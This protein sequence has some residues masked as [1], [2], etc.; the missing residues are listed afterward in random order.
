MTSGNN[1][2]IHI[3]DPEESRTF[4]KITLNDLAYKSLTI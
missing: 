2:D 4:Q 3:I 1:R